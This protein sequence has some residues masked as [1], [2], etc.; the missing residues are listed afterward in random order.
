MRRAGL[1]AVAVLL[2]AAPAAQAATATFS[3]GTLSVLGDIGGSTIAVSQSASVIRVTGPGLAADPDGAGT[4]CEVIAAGTVGCS[5]A[6]TDTIVVNGSNS[7]DILTV[8][9]PASAGADT[10]TLNGNGGGDTLTAEIASGS[11]TSTVLR[12]GSGADT[13]TKNDSSVQLE[14]DGDGDELR[15]GAS[16]LE[17]E[18]TGGPGD[19]VLRGGAGPFSFND[20]V[21]EP[22]ADTYIGNPEP[23]LLFGSLGGTF[24]LGDEISY[25]DRTEPVIVDLSTPGGDGAAGESDDVQA[26]ID[27][28]N[29]SQAAD[30]V[31]CGA[32]PCFVYGGEGADRVTG[33]PEADLLDGGAG[34]DALAGGAGADALDDG[35][36]TPLDATTPLP[37]AYDDELDGGPGDDTLS[38][39]RGAD[40]VRGGDG[41]DSIEVGR[42]V[43][44]AP[45]VPPFGPFDEQP[46]AISLDDV[47]NDGVAGADEGDDFHSDLE[48]VI[49]GDGADTVT[50]SNGADDLQTGGGADTVDGGG[51]ADAIETGTGD[52][53]V[54]VQDG[55]TD[56]ADCGPGADAVTADLP[57]EQPERADAVPNC[58]TVGGTPF[59][60]L[61]APGPSPSP[62]PDTTAPALNLSAATVRLK[63]FRTTS[64]LPV[65]VTCDEA[66]AV[67]GEAFVSG[68]RIAAVG[69][70]S[71]GVGRLARG[72]GRR[73]LRV[74]VAK[75]FRRALRRKARRGVRLTVAVTATD[76][77]GNAARRSVRVRVR[78]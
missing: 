64:A 15:G 3:S 67:R 39:D 51:G 47:A 35:D 44:V 60:P 56:R 68:A 50:G 21:A 27:V 1:L 29:G 24:A 72:T 36:F 61:V 74:K 32:Q 14:G 12:G 2:V 5:S 38:Q 65:L 71:V 4:D 63:A 10:H 31:T 34:N 9:R 55:F 45:P 20:Y 62:V 6:A 7:A 37:P 43:P 69:R 16:V 25:A 46:V 48:Q 8:S 59:G 52:D 57:G 28:V 19:D 70:L 77:A 75:R 54:T 13:L 22:G 73:T 76:A 58:E 53:T 42:P 18:D 30:T 33:G 23:G 17:D 41:F 26:S 40:D 11:G 66:C 49:T 78:R